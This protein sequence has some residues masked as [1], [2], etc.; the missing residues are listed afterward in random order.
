M[1]R[2]HERLT[3]LIGRLTLLGYVNVSTAGGVSE[4]RL[5]DLPPVLLPADGSQMNPD[6]FCAK[7]EIQLAPLERAYAL[8]RTHEAHAAMG[9]VEELGDGIDPSEALANPEG[10]SRLE[11]DTLQRAAQAAGGAA[12]AS[13]G[14]ANPWGTPWSA[15][16]PGLCG[17]TVCVNDRADSALNAGA[18]FA[19]AL[20]SAG[21]MIVCETCGHKRCPHALYHANACTFSNEPG[22]IGSQFR[23]VTARPR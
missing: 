8:G 14:V 13:R 23:H 22:Q 5:G 7:A 20:G 1:A 2:Q 6:A 18:P 17:C 16:E 9:R 12:A 15:A 21:R 11:L 3:Q 10:R 19:D 4:W